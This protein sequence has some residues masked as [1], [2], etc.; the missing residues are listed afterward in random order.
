MENIFYVGSVKAKFSL[1][2]KHRF[3]NNIFCSFGR[4]IHVAIS[5]FT[6]IMIQWTKCV[7][8]FPLLGSK[9]DLVQKK[10]FLSSLR[11]LPLRSFIDPNCFVLAV[12]V[13]VFPIKSRRNSLVVSPYL[14]FSLATCNNSRTAERIFIKFGIEESAKLTGSKFG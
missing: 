6:W 14:G 4:D 5:L 11:V 2:H 8:H 12:V 1:K 13:L 10:A 7:T 9:G 3:H